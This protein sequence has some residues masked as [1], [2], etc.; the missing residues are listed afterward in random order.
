VTESKTDDS[1]TFEFAAPAECTSIIWEVLNGSTV[2]DTATLTPAY[3][4]PISVTVTG[5]AANTGYT[6][7][8][9]LNNTA[10][11]YSRTCTGTITTDATYEVVILNTLTGATIDSVQEDG[12]NFIT[13][14]NGAFPLASG[15]TI[16]GNHDA[17]SGVIQVAVS[18]TF[19]EGNMV[20]N[21]NGSFVECVDFS[22][23]PGTYNF[24]TASYA[25][26]D[27]IGITIAAGTCS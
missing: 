12:N 21:V 3:P 1:I 26:G 23:T 22:G 14:V 5:L 10:E 4:S 24:T 19:T 27:I 16:E 17:F 11:S 25:A 15:G 8:I 18:G 20:L 9:I 13:I 6:Y 7:R 2:I